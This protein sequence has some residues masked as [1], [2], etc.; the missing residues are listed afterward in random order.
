MPTM[1]YPA[2]PV[3]GDR[4]AVL[5]PS[6]GLPAIFP[7]VYERGLAR[8]RDFGLVTV[9]YPTTRASGASAADRARDINAAF[10]DPTIKAVLA[11]IG[12]DDQI[13]VTPHLDAD[14]LRAHPKPYFGYSDNTNLLNYLWNLGVVGYHGG[15]VMVHL[16][17][18]GPMHRTTEDSLRAALFTTGWYALEPPATF[19]DGPG[20]WS[21]AGALDAALPEEDS[22]GW[23]WHRASGVIEAPTWGG[24]LEIISWLLQVGRDV[25]PAGDY[26]GHVL[27][28][29]TSEDMPSASE[30][31]ATLRNMGL[32]GMLARCPAVLV[33]RPQAADVERPATRAERDAY[34]DAQRRAVLRALDTYAP[35]AT[36]VF[37]VD[38]GHADPQ[39]IIPYGGLV[40]VDG[41]ART[42]SVRY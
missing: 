35:D 37:D 20:D 33:G 17:R 1:A 41:D 32:R 38:F 26:A 5:S 10:A 9:E 31:Y 11:T 40:R 14:L 27:L 30:V 21:S 18:N 15:S 25:R 24:N 2:K 16:G 23:V 6:A 7:H 42:I 39:V 28:I 36:V 22:A 13:T 29:E 19:R 8:L 12:G 34:R 4:V 3:P